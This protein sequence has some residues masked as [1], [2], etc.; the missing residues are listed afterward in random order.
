MRSDVRARPE[1][2]RLALLSWCAA[3]LICAGAGAR[4]QGRVPKFRDYPVKAVYRGRPARVVLTPD[5][6]LFRTRLRA[7]GRERPNFAG[8]YVVTTWGCGTGCRSG[9]V[10]DLKTG[11][12]HPLPH[13]LCCWPYGEPPYPEPLEFRPDSR[14]IVLTGARGATET[15]DGQVG[16]HFYE[17]RNGRF[18]HLHTAPAGGR[19]Q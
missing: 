8:R 3:A 6:R 5:T 17:F 4:A 15:E 19:G 2:S 11:R 10:V 1:L 9:A 14:L 13:Q 12:V 7:A 18:R 16:V